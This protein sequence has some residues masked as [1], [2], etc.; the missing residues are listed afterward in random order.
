MASGAALT[1]LDEPFAAL[2]RASVNFLHEVLADA[3]HH[4]NRAFVIADHEAPE[5]IPLAAC[6]DLAWNIVGG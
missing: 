4:P 2:D 1:L 6:I 3:A 5:G